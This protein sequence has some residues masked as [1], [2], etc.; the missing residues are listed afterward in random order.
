MNRPNLSAHE[1]RTY[2]RKLRELTARLSGGVEQLEAEALVAPE[3]A[4]AAAPAHEADRAVRESEEQVA[5]ALLASEGHI[6]AEA[7]MA[8]LRLANGTFGMCGQC[9]RPIAKARLDA[10]PYA[11]NCVRCERET[12]APDAA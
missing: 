5:R 2:R 7:N 3:A 9:G 11:R 4:G 6:L 10:V 1:R 8:L 12:E